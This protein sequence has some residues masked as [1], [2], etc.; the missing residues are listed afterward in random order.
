M[1]L[2]YY[3][4]FLLQ[5]V[6]KACV[7]KKLRDLSSTLEEEKLT[8][9]GLVMIS[10]WY[11]YKSVVCESSVMKKLD[12]IAEIVENQLTLNNP[13]HPI[14]H[15]AKST[16]SQWRNKNL[17]NHQFNWNDTSETIDC[18]YKVF[19]NQLEFQ[20]INSGDYHNSED[21]DFLHN[22]NKVPS[23]FLSNVKIQLHLLTN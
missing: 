17:S 16:R 14:T 23:H 6:K 11:Q 5:Y 4:K 19:F 3:A 18:M 12:E 1:T 22:L 7:A 15:V 2:N 13:K 8:E 21:S 9:K 20:V 10:D